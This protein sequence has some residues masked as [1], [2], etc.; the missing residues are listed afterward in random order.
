M[1]VAKGTWGPD[2]DAIVVDFTEADVVPEATTRCDAC[3]AVVPT[4]LIVAKYV[5]GK[6][7]AQVVVAPHACGPQA[8]IEGFFDALTDLPDGALDD[9]PDPKDPLP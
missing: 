4:L 3:K 2:D 8:A 9:E 1:N 5:D 6:A 7:Y